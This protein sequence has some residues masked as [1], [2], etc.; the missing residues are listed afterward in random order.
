MAKVERSID[1]DVPVQV[2]YNQWTQFEQFPQFM[3]NV[4]EVQQ[5][6]DT[7]L[8]WVADVAGKRKEW[9]AEITEQAPDQRIAWTSTSGARN[10]GVVTFH[11]V[12]DDTTKVML[13]MDVEPEGAVE[14][15]GAA[16]GV[17]EGQVQGDLERF[18]EFIESR[19]TESGAWRGEVEQTNVR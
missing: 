6:G 5:L 2:A 19:G 18:K 8:H 14:T 3:E 9:D 10:A 4:K 7:R 1:V 16:L 11:R 12:D 17:L 15:A 13:Q